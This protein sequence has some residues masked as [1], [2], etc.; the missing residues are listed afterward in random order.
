M[1]YELIWEPR[2]VT[3]LFFGHVT[4][5]DLV[6]SVKSVHG[7]SR[8]D[9]LRFVINDFLGCKELSVTAEAVDEISAVD[10][11]AAMS[12]PN[13]AIAV[14]ATAPAIVDLASQYAQSPMNAY[15][16]RIFPTQVEGRAWLGLD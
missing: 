6:Q 15:P 5:D 7:D 4:A 10:G 11:A 9:S 1:S 16:T 13:I 3:K 2:G 14:V 8:F 12:N